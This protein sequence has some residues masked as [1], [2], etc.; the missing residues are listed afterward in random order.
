MGALWGH[1]SE[2]LRPNGGGASKIDGDQVVGSTW[3]T[4]VLLLLLLFFWLFSEETGAGPGAGRGGTRWET[5]SPNIRS[6]APDLAASGCEGGHHRSSM[7]MIAM[8]NHLDTWMIHMRMIP[9]G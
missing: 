3:A 7:W 6:A 9:C 8:R 5:G 4:S 1:L 2:A